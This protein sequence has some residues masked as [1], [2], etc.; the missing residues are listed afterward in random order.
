M[1]LFTFNTSYDELIAET[2]LQSIRYNAEYWLTALAKNSKLDIWWLN[3]RNQHPD[4][5]K[6]GIASGHATPV[7][8]HDITEQIARDDGYDTVGDLIP[9]LGELHSMNYED[10]LEHRWA[11][12]RWVWVERYWLDTPK[13]TQTALPEM[14]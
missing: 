13:T 9:V 11:V 1:T 12:V 3:P 8:G 6:L 5:K 7:Y 14:C 4:C 10:V 2:K